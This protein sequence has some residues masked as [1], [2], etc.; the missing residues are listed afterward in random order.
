MISGGDRRPKRHSQEKD[1]P[2]IGR[3]LSTYA[4]PTVHKPREIERFHTQTRRCV[5]TG[6]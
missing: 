5:S 6:G 4:P 2:R 1:E 3:S